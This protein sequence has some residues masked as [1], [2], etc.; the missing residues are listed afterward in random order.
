M[1]S[2]KLYS[3]LPFCGANKNLAVIDTDALIGNRELLLREIHKNAPTVRDICV[4]KADAYGHGIAHCV[5]A[6]VRSGCGFFAV[7]CIEEAVALRGLLDTLG[8]TAEILIL[9]YT[10]PENA[11]ILEEKNVIQ[12]VFSEEYANELSHHAT[13]Q[14]RVHLKLDTGMSRIGFFVRSAGGAAEAAGVLSRV[15]GLGGLKVCG[16]FTHFSRADEMTPEGDAFT[17]EQ[18]CRFTAVI[19]E[20]KKMGLDCGMLHACNSA[21]ALRFP[22]F[23]LDGV[24]LGIMLYGGGVRLDSLCGLRPVMSLYTKITHLHTL[25][26]GEPLGYG[27][28]YVAESDR[29]IATLPIGYADGFLRG[30]GGAPVCVL[31]EEGEREAHLVGRICMDQCMVDVTGVGARVGDSVRLFGGDRSTLDGLARRAE[32]IDYEC[33]CLISARVP[34]KAK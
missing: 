14:L 10:A 19:G 31:T 34:R 33:L 8:S 13:G 29:V 24:R 25:Y 15:F 11:P 17:R 4:V 21:G 16:T 2:Y 1:D 9:G 6:L 26:A 32:T 30:Y 3:S 27:G 7:S 28:T 5:P 12:C 18:F 23:A 20:L 22:E